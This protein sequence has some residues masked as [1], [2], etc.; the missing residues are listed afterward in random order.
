MSDIV[1]DS[2]TLKQALLDRWDELGLTGHQIS[3]DAKKRGLNG[4][5]E[6]AIS[7]WK[8]RP[9]SKGA[10][11]QYQILALAWLYGIKVKLVIGE[12]VMEGKKLRY[13]VPQ[14]F[15]EEKAIADFNQM[16][17]FH[18]IVA[19]LAEKVPVKKSKKKK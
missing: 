5:T 9:Y 7:V 4:V 6:R 12:P 11:N 15:N 3:A 2:E 18:S 8:N 19:E 16:F 10:L 14:P 17:P 1:K 13:V